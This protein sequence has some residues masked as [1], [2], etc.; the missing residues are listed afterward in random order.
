M[1]TSGSIF[2][3]LITVQHRDITQG[4]SADNY[5]Y[6]EIKYPVLLH[7]SGSLTLSN[8]QSNDRRFFYE[9]P[10]WF[11]SLRSLKHLVLWC[12]RLLF[13]QIHGT[14][15]FF[16]VGIHPLPKYPESSVVLRSLFTRKRR[17]IKITAPPPPCTLPTYNSLETTYLLIYLPT[18]PQPGHYL[19]THQPH[20][21]FSSICFAVCFLLAG[22]SRGRGGR[23]GALQPIT[24]YQ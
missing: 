16:D 19:P 21:S 8:E 13:S 11:Q 6:W 20:R 5:D 1:I 14:R 23:G 17:F 3:L 9:T 18:Y 15:S 22:A 12:E 24:N 7:V 10:W 4:I 2:R